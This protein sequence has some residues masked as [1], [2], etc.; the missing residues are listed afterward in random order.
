MEFFET[1]AKEN[2]QVQEAFTQLTRE[3]IKTKDKTLEKGDKNLKLDMGKSNDL[4]VKKR[5]VVK[6]ESKIDIEK[7]IIHIL[8]KNN[9]FLFVF[10]YN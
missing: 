9:Y 7:L 8:F 3:V 6:N 4:S 2:F 10:L 5:N 1:S